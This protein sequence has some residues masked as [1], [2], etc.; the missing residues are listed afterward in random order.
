MAYNASIEVENADKYEFIERGMLGERVPQNVDAIRVLGPEGEVAFEDEGRGR[1]T[2]PEGNY[3]IV[4]RG[5][6]RD[7]S[8]QAEFDQPYRVN[9]VL[10]SGFDVRNP[11]LGVISPGGRASEADDA[12]TVSWEETTF[13][14]VRFYDELRERALLVFGSFWIILCAIFILPYLILRPRKR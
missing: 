1:I 14:E 5:F 7:N 4:Y 9:V 13:A 8:L 10:P 11:F 2:F 12:I 6:I 3:T